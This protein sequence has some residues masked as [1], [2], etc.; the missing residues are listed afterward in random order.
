[1]YLSYSIFEIKNT[2]EIFFH[3]FHYI[4]TS[5]HPLS[6]SEDPVNYATLIAMRHGTQH[7]PSAATTFTTT[8]TYL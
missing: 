7:R 3:D 6:A 5:G 1:M 2:L 8:T 4:V